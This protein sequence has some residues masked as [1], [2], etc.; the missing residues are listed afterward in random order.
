[1]KNLSN[2]SNFTAISFSKV[3]SVVGLTALAFSPVALSEVTLEAD[4]GWGTSIS[5]SIPIFAVASDHDD[6][7]QAF[8]IQ[9]GFNPANINFHVVAPKTDSGLTI[10]GHFQVD[11]HLNA[12][13]G[14]QNG[15]LFESRVANIQVSGDFGTIT[16][17]K[18]FG[19]FNTNAIG[20]IASQGGVGWLGGGA[21]TGNATGGRI[22]T[23]YVYAN[24]N[25]Q[26]KFTS[27]DMN[28][29][30]YKIAFI[31]PEEPQDA[32]I[33]TSTP[34]L[35]GQVTYSGES[36]RVWTGAFQQAVSVTGAQAFDYDM[37]GFDVGAHY[38]AG[39]FGLTVNYTDTTG[40]GADGLYGGSINDA[41]VDA[42]QWFFEADYMLDKTRFGISYGEG[43]QDSRAADP[44][45]GLSAA[46]EVDN[47]LTMLFVHHQLSTQFRIVGELQDYQSDVQNDYNAIILGFQFDF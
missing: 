20:D 46:A 45:I 5:G 1:M 25:P 22:G 32:S 33:E 43:S 6:S 16:L 47:E 15:G 44:S 41:D 34:R 42:T 31:N 18:D 36:F 37:Q 11:T 35:E 21:D 38:Q 29:F 17:G 30:V 12:P 40:I 4:N 14:V 13:N 7:E 27:N 28:G 39:A 10:S 8:R 19:V 23:G 24:F 26:I 3:A 2:R 9:S